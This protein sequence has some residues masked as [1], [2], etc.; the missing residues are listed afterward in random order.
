[1]KKLIAILTAAILLTVSVC[2]SLVAVASVDISTLRPFASVNADG[3]FKAHV[4][5]QGSYASTDFSVTAVD[6]F[7]SVTSE[8]IIKVDS[9]AET[10]I[11]GNALNIAFGGWDYSDDW[12]FPL[13][14]TDAIVFYVKMP[15]AEADGFSHFYTSLTISWGADKTTSG[16]SWPQLVENAP[17]YLLA[18][19][20]TEWSA[21]TA[22]GGLDVALPGGFEGYVRFPWTSFGLSAT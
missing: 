7:T 4:Q 20:T 10:A 22:A 8:K 6:N 2:G 17:Y 21:Q 9:A 18:K 1:M 16:K 12:M 11:T 15:A 5:P 3:T 14:G 19:D 13:A